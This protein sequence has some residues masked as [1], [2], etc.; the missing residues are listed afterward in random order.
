MTQLEKEGT[1]SPEYL[2]KD[3]V[4]LFLDHAKANNAPLTYRWYRDF[5]KS[6]CETIP[7]TLKVKELKLHHAQT[8]LTKCY[9]PDRQSE[10]SSRGNLFSEARFQL[11]RQR[12]GLLGS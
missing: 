3:L 6:F 12:Y 10:H 9:P 8:W 1:P 5:L 7:A 11:G 4:F 2:V